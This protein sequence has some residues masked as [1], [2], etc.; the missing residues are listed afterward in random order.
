M[1]GINMGSFPDNYGDTHMLQG[2][3]REGPH[4]GIYPLT[5]SNRL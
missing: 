1:H 3:T 2:G 4:A 5:S